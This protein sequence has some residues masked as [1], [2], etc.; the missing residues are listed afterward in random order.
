MI[1]PTYPWIFDIEND[2]KEL[3]NIASANTWVG[4]AM[5]KKVGAPYSESLKG[6]PNIK[7]GAEGPSEIDGSTTEMPPLDGKD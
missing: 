6:H 2:P 3:W 1:R 4:V 5:A 7:P